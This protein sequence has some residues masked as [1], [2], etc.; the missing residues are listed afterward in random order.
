MWLSPPLSGTWIKW[1]SNVRSTG[2]DAH[3][4][5]GVVDRSGRR[6]HPGGADR[7]VS[8]LLVGD[9]EVAEHRQGICPL[10]PSSALVGLCRPP[11]YAAG[12]L[13]AAGWMVCHSS[14][15]RHNNQS[16]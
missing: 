3:L 8:G 2:G 1:R 6:R 12:V 5:G 14:R 9:R 10:M 15:Y 4:T 7:A 13:K 16:L 11:G